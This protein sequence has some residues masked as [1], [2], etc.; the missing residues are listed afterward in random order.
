M[1]AF[2]MPRKINRCA[3]IMAYQYI[4]PRKP[5]GCHH[6]VT[7]RRRLSPKSSMVNSKRPS[8]G[9]FIPNSKDKNCCGWQRITFQESI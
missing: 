4:K 9:P 5:C 1:I 7:F 6:A 8:P 3:G 2:T